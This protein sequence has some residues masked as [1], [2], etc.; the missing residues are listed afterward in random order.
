MGVNFRF[1]YYSLLNIELANIASESEKGLDE[2]AEKLI[3]NDRGELVIRYY[4][5]S[6]IN[7][8][9]DGDFFV[10]LGHSSSSLSVNNSYR[11]FAKQDVR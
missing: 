2:A 11:A 8:K 6:T 9:I 7:L 1:I 5:T 10:S 4:F 3:F